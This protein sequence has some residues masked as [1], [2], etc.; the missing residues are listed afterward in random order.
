MDDARTI[1]VTFAGKKFKAAPISEGQMVALTMIR[2]NGSSQL[3]L[4]IIMSV[5]ESSVGPDTW[6]DM[7]E[8][9][10]LGEAELSDFTGALEKITKATV[11]ARKKD[12]GQPELIDGDSA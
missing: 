4:K 5:I 2:A 7:V 12:A 9:L 1:S 6:S 10:A 8:S 11:A 3:P